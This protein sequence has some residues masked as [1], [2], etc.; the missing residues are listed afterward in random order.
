MRTCDTIVRV[1]VALRAQKKRPNKVS[2][3]APQ[4]S[5]L[6]TALASACLC[7]CEHNMHGRA[8]VQHC[9]LAHTHTHSLSVSALFPAGLAVC[10]WFLRTCYE[11]D[12]IQLMRRQRRRRCASANKPEQRN[13]KLD[14]TLRT[15]KLYRINAQ[16]RCGGD[17]ST[18]T[19]DD[20]ALRP[21]TL[22]CQHTTTTTKT[23]PP[24]FGSIAITSLGARDTSERVRA[25]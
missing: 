12:D 23:L 25:C 5:A 20:D 3:T 6:P 11:L 9:Q 19:M 24:I 21:D 15:S 4:A 18:L 1:R 8:C 7:T 16:R 2:S 14:E 22:P 17:R 10:W 13:G